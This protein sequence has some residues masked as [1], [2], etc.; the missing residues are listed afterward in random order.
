MTLA[1]K[2]NTYNVTYNVEKGKVTLE[3]CPTDDQLSPDGVLLDP[4]QEKFTDEME[5]FEAYLD[6]HPFGPEGGFVPYVEVDGERAWFAMNGD[7]EWQ[8]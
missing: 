7:C 4:E 5:S 8:E 3:C 1:E 2:L 6:F